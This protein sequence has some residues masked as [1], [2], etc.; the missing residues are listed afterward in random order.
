M[1]NERNRAIIA[2]Y[3]ANAGKVSGYFADRPLLLLTSK[4]ARTGRPHTTPVAYSRDGDRLI[5]IA[6]KAGA[7]ISP[8]WYHN[9]VANPDATVELGGETFPVR[10]VVVQG[11]ER[12]RLYA[13]HAAI[14]PVF[15]EYQQKTSRRIPVIALERKQGLMVWTRSCRS[16]SGT[17]PAGSS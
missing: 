13:N 4:G 11:E 15:N 14:M 17:D 10:A 6:S 9:L 7:L 3:R 12:D 16:R 2:E 8:D 1:V 5:V